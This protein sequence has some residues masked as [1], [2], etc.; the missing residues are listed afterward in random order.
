MMKE[1]NQSDTIA[2]TCD[3]NTGRRQQQQQQQAGREVAASIT[4]F[5]VV[6]HRAFKLPKSSNKTLTLLSPTPKR[7]KITYHCG[8]VAIVLF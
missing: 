2:Y 4:A 3:F 5:E 6:L 1:A 8:K 7:L